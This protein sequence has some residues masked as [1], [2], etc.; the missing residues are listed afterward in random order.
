MSFNHSIIAVNFANLFP[1]HLKIKHDLDWNYKLPTLGKLGQNLQ[2]GKKAKL[3]I[4]PDGKVVKVARP[5]VLLFGTAIKKRLQYVHLRDDLKKKLFRTLK[6]VNLLLKPWG[7][8]LYL[9]RTSP[10]WQNFPTRQKWDIFLFFFSFSKGR[11][12][13]TWSM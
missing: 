11:R 3:W 1:Q 7:G 2:A 12:L 10:Q 13:D 6:F 8:S 5:V 9:A 4:L